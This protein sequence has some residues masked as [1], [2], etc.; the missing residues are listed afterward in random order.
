MVADEGGAAE[1]TAM[2]T[3]EGAHHIW[4][5][6]ESAGNTA[7]PGDAAETTDL[8]VA[9]ADGPAGK[10]KQALRGNAGKT[11]PRPKRANTGEGMGSQIKTVFHWPAHTKL[12]QV[13]MRA[14][15]VAVA[16]ARGLTRSLDSGA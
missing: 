8:Q 13:P 3:V 1:H 12:P 10:N 2:P 11:G 6:N 16:R 7:G 14:W 9:A 15:T 5:D 4:P